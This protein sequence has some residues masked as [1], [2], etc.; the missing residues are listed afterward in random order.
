MTLGDFLSLLL[1]FPTNVFFIPFCF[2]L[3]IMLIDLFFNVF[4]SLSA[5]LDFLDL[6]DL[7][8][9]GLLLPQVLSK[10]PLTVALCLSFFV[11]TVLTFYTSEFLADAEL[12]EHL[13]WLQVGLIPIQAY[14]ALAISAWV[15]KPLAPLFDKKKAF[16]AI[17]FV[18]MK[19]RV[20]S[21]VVNDQIG[22][23]IV[24][25]KGSE[26]LLD[27]MVLNA[28]DDI[29]YGDEVFIVEQDPSSR[30]YVVKK[31]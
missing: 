15:L 9:S 16:A 3:L 27:A 23:I 14:A 2:F 1:A 29:Q 7:P 19:G 10:V 13:F 20:H 26:S 5:D 17:N 25:H 22:E 4:E 8:G 30:R 11:A 24:V 12:T 31:S 18:G 21:S 6:D 28:E